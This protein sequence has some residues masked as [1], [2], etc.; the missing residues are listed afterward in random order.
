MFNLIRLLFGNLY[1]LLEISNV[2]IWMMVEQFHLM[3]TT[4]TIRKIFSGDIYDV[5]HIFR[6][7]MYL[8]RQPKGYGIKGNRLTKR[9]ADLIGLRD[10]DIYVN[11]STKPLSLINCFCR[12]IE[13]P[14]TDQV[15]YR[16]LFYSFVTSFL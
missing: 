14:E 2:L 4:F 8:R 1:Q 13:E 9:M 3:V 16:V 7:T 12:A 10:I 5:K 15:G 11:G 6:T